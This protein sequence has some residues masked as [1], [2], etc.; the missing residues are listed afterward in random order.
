M[1]AA[2]SF[3]PAELRLGS[4]AVTDLLAALILFVVLLVAKKYLTKL[5][6]TIIDKNPTFSASIK[7]FLKSTVNVA[8][9]VLIVLLV[10]DKLGIPITTLVA[11]ISIAGVAL[12]LS[13]QSI[14]ENLFA[15]VTILLTRPVEVGEFVEVDG[16][17]GTVRK[18]TLFYT[19]LEGVDGRAIYVPN[20]SVTAT[21]VI[22][23]SDN[24]RRRI[25]LVITASYD[26]EPDKVIA[27]LL[28]AA[29]SVE[30]VLKDPAPMASVA[31]YGNSSIEY[32]LFAYVPGPKFLTTKWALTR[33]IFYSFKENGVTMTYDHLNVHIVDEPDSA[34]K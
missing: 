31:N 7:S 3:A 21:K 20:K 15:G 6:T 28:K 32:N 2:L 33:Q 26:D 30:D 29:D 4:F 8:A 5:T 24:P 27:A 17:T 19:V 10:A 34:K 12:S 22:N 13:L 14:L 25:D 18:L 11:L 23:Y 9:W 1:I 16:L